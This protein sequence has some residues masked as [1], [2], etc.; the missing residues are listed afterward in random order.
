MCRFTS[1]TPVFLALSA[2][3]VTAPAKANDSQL[4]IFEGHADIGAKRQV[5]HLTQP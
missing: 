5:E 2:L 1:V 4:G 3:L